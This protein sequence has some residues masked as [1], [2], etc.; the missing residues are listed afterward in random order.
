MSDS[1]SPA[2]DNPRGTVFIVAALAAL[3]VVGW[4]LMFFGL[5]M[6]RNTP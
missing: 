2:T 4:L 6:P 3:I 5:F 1:S